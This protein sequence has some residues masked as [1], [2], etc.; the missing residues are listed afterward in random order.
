MAAAATPDVPKTN[1]PYKFCMSCAQ[2]KD[3]NMYEQ[4][5]KCYGK[6]VKPRTYNPF[7]GKKLAK[8]YVFEGMLFKDMK[9]MKESG[10]VVD[11]KI[12]AL[13]NC[14]FV[15]DVTGSMGPYIAAAKQNV[16]EI[17][18][19]FEK[20]QKQLFKKCYDEDT[21]YEHIIRTAVVPYRDFKDKTPDHLDFMTDGAKVKSY[22][23]GL[24]AEGGDDA[25]EDLYGGLERALSK[26]SW[27]AAHTLTTNYIMIITDAP[28][29][30]PFLCAKEKD[31]YPKA[32]TEKQ[33][34][35]LI[36]KIKEKNIDMQFYKAGQGTGD[37]DRTAKYIAKL[38]DDDEKNY[39]MQV[40]LLPVSE[41]ANYAVACAAASGAS[42]AT[43]R[44]RSG[45][46]AE[47]VYDIV[48]P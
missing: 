7:D 45:C 9:D 2:A 16:I 18:D 33:W 44:L 47:K 14:V 29:H 3:A 27:S 46:A 43:S 5:E 41:L 21:E 40:V 17:M 42:S 6:N 25:P 15:M 23:S 8:E 39:K 19:S 38:Y 28:G 36:E 30:C 24:R 12:V 10:L 20:N 35:D 26:L 34:S 32:N 22:L 31:D 37:L 4:C 11:G 48:K 1:S 13:T